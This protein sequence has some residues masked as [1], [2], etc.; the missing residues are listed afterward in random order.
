MLKILVIEPS[1]A[2][3]EFITSSIKQEFKAS[4]T[5]CPQLKSIDTNLDMDQYH[6]AIIRNEFE[7]KKA[8]SFFYKLLEVKK[9]TSQ[10]D[11]KEKSNNY[12]QSVILCPVRDLCFF[13]IW[14]NGRVSFLSEIHK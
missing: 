1:S 10:M 13:L 2:V 3:I 8:A 6:L 5:V 14:L 12:F 4:I 11:F 7:N 9:I